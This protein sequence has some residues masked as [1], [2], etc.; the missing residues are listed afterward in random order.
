MGFWRSRRVLVT[1]GASFIGSHLAEKLVAAGAA[2][3]VADD[4]SS[5]K[6]ANLG[7]IEGD[8]EILQGDLRDLCFACSVARNIEIVF[9]LAASHGGR[10]YID[11]HPVECSSNLLLDGSVFRAAALAGVERVCFASSACVYPV[12]LQGKPAPGRPVFLSE[13][14]ADPLAA[15]CSPDGEYGWAKLM[16]EMALRAYHRQ[17]GMGAVSCR[18]FTAYG[19]RENETHAVIALIAKAFLRMDPFE[20]WGTGEQ[21]RNFTYVGDI[22]EGMMRAAERI[23][24]GSAVNIGTAEHITLREAAERI[25]EISGFRPRRIATDPSKPVGVFS[26]SSDNTRARRLLDWEP[27]TSFRDGLRRT[28]DWYFS[29]RQAPTPDTLQHALF[30]RY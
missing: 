26:R 4:F 28:I 20:I 5:G 13:D 15:P 27:S 9:H 7:N 21:D 10:A 22:V 23:T 17:L 24:D 29:A 11:T 12:G 3:R 19:E 16:G 25:F 18:L 1:G 30:E 14:L 6:R 2:V 8:L